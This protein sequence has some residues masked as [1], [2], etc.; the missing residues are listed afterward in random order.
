[1]AQ[2][3]AFDIEAAALSAARKIHQRANPGQRICMA[4]IEA[5]YNE[6]LA[7]PDFKAKHRGDNTVTAMGCAVTAHHP[8]VSS[9]MSPAA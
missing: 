1:M 3:Q 7:S 9:T 5:T 2:S 4:D 6:L 8:G